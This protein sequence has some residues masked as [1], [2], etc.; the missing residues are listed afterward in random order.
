[1]RIVL[2]I[3]LTALLLS[4]CAAFVRFENT[5]TSVSDSTLVGCCSYFVV[6]MDEDTNT[7]SISWRRMEKQLSTALDSRGFL[8]AESPEAADLA[9]VVGAGIG[10]PRTVTFSRPVYGKTGEVVTGSTTTGSIYSYG[11]TAT[12]RANTTNTSKDTYGV[13]GTTTSS[14]AVYDRWLI[15]SA[16]DMNNKSANDDYLESWRTTVRSSGSSGDLQRVVPYMIAAS[17][18]YLGGNLASAKKVTIRE[19]SSKV[20]ALIE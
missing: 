4:S 13:V 11:N 3:L 12:G 7:A 9:I 18:D 6:P 19:G 17:Q 1:M 5:V 14:A 10:D 2:P 16:Y 15:V 20:Q 8:K